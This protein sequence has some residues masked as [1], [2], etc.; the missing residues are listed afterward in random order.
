MGKRRE[1]PLGQLAY[2]V[3]GI[4]DSVHRW[5][6]IREKGSNDPFWPDGVNM[7]LVRNH[8]IYYQEQIRELCS[9]NG[10]IEP[11]EVDWDLPPKVADRLYIGD[12]KGRRFD[13]LMYMNGGVLE[14]NVPDV[15][16]PYMEGQICLF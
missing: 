15:Y 8:I 4:K 10:M 3:E 1:D 11:E 9:E 6:E 12:R 2:C 16:S 7:N 5:N 14:F 13:N